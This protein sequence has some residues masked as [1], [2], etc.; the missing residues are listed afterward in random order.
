MCSQMEMLKEL[1]VGVQEQGERATLKLEHD[2]DVKVTKPTEEDDIEAYLTTFER[3]MKVS[4]ER[5]SFKLALQLV[6]KAYATMLPKDAKDYNK[7]KSAIPCRYNI[8][9]ESYRQWFHSLTPKA[10]EMSREVEARLWDL[11]TILWLKQC[12]MVQAILDQVIL[13]QL[14]STLLENVRVWV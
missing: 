4:R 14:L 13:E 1:V 2:R 8:T 6:G 7:L 10:G 3:L 9:E 11:A 12:T 5:W